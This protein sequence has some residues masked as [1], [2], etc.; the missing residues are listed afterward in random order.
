[1]TIEQL[2]AIGI[3]FIWTGFVRTGLGFG[4]AALGLPLLLLV[5][6]K[7]LYFLPIIGTHLLFFTSLTLSSRLQNVDWKYI[8][9]TFAIMVIPMILG[10]MGLVNMPNQWLVWLVYSITLTYGAMWI[11]D[12]EIKSKNKAIDTVL[13][14]LGGYVSG[15]SLIGAPLIVAVYMQHVAKERLRETLF[16][17]WFVIVAFKMLS[18]LV[19]GVDMH[20]KMAFM[21]LPLAA[22]GHII[23]LKAHE[24]IIHAKDNKFKQIVG[25]GLVVVSL[26][27]LVN[28]FL[29][30]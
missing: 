23:G 6:D 4:G 24:H 19:I 22:V 13:L 5:H 8:A 30:T 14:L 28:S 10:I 11:I 7:P 26:L 12:Y 25:T 1:M 3:I 17:L 15:T 18:F 20:F 9:K 27:G 2:I 21:L 16:V 29:T